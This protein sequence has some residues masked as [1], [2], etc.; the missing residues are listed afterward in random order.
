VAVLCPGFTVDCLETIEEMGMANR[1]LFLAAGGRD[2]H[3][4]PCLNDHPAWIDAMASIIEREAAGWAR[5]E[6]ART[7]GCCDTT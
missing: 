6:G 5:G 1:E 3:L 2:F 4:V 7:S